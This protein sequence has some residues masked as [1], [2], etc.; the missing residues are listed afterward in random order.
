MASGVVPVDVATIGTAVFRIVVSSA[1][2]K[3]A[4]ATSHGS[5]RRIAGDVFAVV[6]ASV[7]KLFCGCFGARG[8]FARQGYRSG[9]RSTCF[10]AAPHVQRVDAGPIAVDFD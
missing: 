6:G 8:R 2:M 7:A 4:T 3:N 9:D 10:P 1:S 5:T